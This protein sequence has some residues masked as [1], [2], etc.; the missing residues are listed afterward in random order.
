[1]KNCK[2][3]SPITKA[4]N[5]RLLAILEVLRI[6]EPARIVH[7]FVHD[8]WDP[9]WMRGWTFIAREHSITRISNM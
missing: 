1:M 8:L 7:N 9:H 5:K 2:I 3:N 4:I 6:I